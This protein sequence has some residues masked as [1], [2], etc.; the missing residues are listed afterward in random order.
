MKQDTLYVILSFVTCEVDY[1][2]WHK[3]FDF[4]NV[5]FK[6]TLSCMFSYNK[7]R[8]LGKHMKIKLCSTSNI[9]VKHYKNVTSLTSSYPIDDVVLR[10]LTNIEELIIYQSS[11]N[12]YDAGNIA[13]PHFT[14]ITTLRV[15]NIDDTTFPYICALTTLKSLTLDSC[16]ISTCDG[17]QRLTNLVDLK[18][19][20]LYTH[21]FNPMCIDQL[22]QLRTLN[23]WCCNLRTLELLHLPQLKILNISQACNLTS[24][25]GIEKYKELSVLHVYSCKELSDIT[26]VKQLKKLTK[27]EFPNC[28]NVKLLQLLTY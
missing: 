10:Q 23:L 7:E 24:L 8:I 2:V 3:T 19:S 20:N 6:Y 28:D 14:K 25:K 16:R 1:I 18:I 22:P 26:H 9:D 12:Y 5:L 15:M 11:N 13:V 27:I 21:L 4:N 17:I